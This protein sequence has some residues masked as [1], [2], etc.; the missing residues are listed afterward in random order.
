MLTFYECYATT[1]YNERK[2]STKY[3]GT[4]VEDENNVQNH[5]EK[6]TWENLNEKYQKN[7][8]CYKFTIANVKKGRKIYFFDDCYDRCFNTVKEWKEK[9]LNI[10]IKY[11]YKEN[12]YVS[13]N[14]VLKLHNVE[15]AIRYLNE[16]GLTI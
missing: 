8:N 1:Y 14:D 11:E 12:K 10:E 6:I 3:C 16:R 15:K 2:V 9:E 13:I 5:I 4:L 7:G